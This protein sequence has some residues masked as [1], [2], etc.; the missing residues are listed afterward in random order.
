[1]VNLSGRF[2]LYFSMFCFPF[3]PIP[4]LCVI[5]TQPYIYPDD[6]LH[7]PENLRM[8]EAV[9]TVLNSR[10]GHVR[11]RAGEHSWQNGEKYALGMFPEGPHRLV[12]VMKFLIG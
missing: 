4:T 3:K 10:Y 2:Q 5:I 1:M 12:T 9:L 7:F 8:H 6:F 11:F